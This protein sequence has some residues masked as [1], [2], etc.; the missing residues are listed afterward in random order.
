MKLFK[1]KFFIRS[2]D[3]CVVVIFLIYFLIL[4]FVT[5]VRY[6]RFLTTANDL[7]IFNQA[8]WTTLY[9]GKFFYETPDMWFNPNGSFFGVHFSPIL[10]LFLPF[11]AVYPSPET[12]LVIQAFFVALPII[13]IY[14]ISKDK[15]SIYS[16]GVVILY[17]L[18]TPMFFVSL[19]DFHL[20][21][22]VPTFLLFAVYFFEKRKYSLYFVFIVLA[23]STIEFVPLITA[24]F[25]ICVI[26]KVLLVS[27]KSI[28]IVNFLKNKDVFYG[29]L[30]I[31]ASIVWFFVALQ[32]KFYLNPYVSPIPSHFAHILNSSGWSVLFSYF[33]IYLDEK[34]FYVILLLGPLMF[35]SFLSPLELLPVLPWFF[36]CFLTD[37]KPYFLIQYQYSAFVTAFIFY[38]FIKSLEKLAMEG[39]KVNKYRVKRIFVLLVIVSLLFM[40]FTV[41]KYRLREDLFGLYSDEHIELLKHIVSLI[42]EDATILV[43]NDIFPHVSSRKNAYLYPPSKSFEPDFILFDIKLEFYRSPPP[44]PPYSIFIPAYLREHR[45]YGVY[46]SADGIVLYKKG[47]DASPVFY[48]PYMRILDYRDL[49]LS[50]GKTIYDNVSYSKIV[51]FHSRYDDPGVFWFGPYEIFPPGNYTVIFCLKVAE[52]VNG[53]IIVLDVS[54]N[55]GSE[56][57]AK[58]IVNGSEFMRQNEWQNF[59]LS[60]ALDVPR[61]LEIRGIYVNSTTNVYLDYI[62]VKQID[63]NV[64]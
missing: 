5:V 1:D 27:G 36:M 56:I 14:L 49:I 46:A 6:H 35:L 48:V 53:T 62:L 61:E 39:G 17:I 41:E 32:V 42:P 8:F 63:V 31:L 11:Y 23:L 60:L 52:I 10:F 7:G 47:Y 18:Y 13:P 21:A 28:K 26:L 20:E 40:A 2:T 54:T 9:C 59:T 50:S 24:M 51:L 16:L 58:R 34:L 57:L 25:G 38:S 4:S 12:L 30:T 3:L 43:Q 64:E 44:Y 22:F 37:Y 55:L 15:M 45:D 19:F 29:L 33:Q